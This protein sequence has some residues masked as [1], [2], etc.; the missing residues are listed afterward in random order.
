MNMS[1]A[2]ENRYY[3]VEPEG[4]APPKQ[5]WCSIR[6]ECM[7]ELGYALFYMTYSHP[8][9]W[10]ETQRPRVE[11]LCEE[12]ETNHNKDDLEWWLGF[13]RRIAEEIENMC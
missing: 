6:L 2:S 5:C 11:A 9:G 13:Q 3:T 1:N 10:W 4:V 12:L 7:R 8:G